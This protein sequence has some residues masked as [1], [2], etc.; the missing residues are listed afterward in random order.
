MVS[1]SQDE[2]LRQLVTSMKAGKNIE[3]IYEGGQ[4]KSSPRPIRPCGLVRNPDGDY[5]H[6]ECGIDGQRKR[7]YL[8]KIKSV[9]IK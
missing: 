6:A 7:F 8:D 9:I 4:T 3:I 1:G 5:I 2:K